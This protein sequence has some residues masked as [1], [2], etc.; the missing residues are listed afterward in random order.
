MLR[1]SRGFLVDLL[2]LG[3]FL[4]LVVCYVYNY[5]NY[6]NTIR[7]GDRDGIPD[8]DEMSKYLTDPNSKDTDND[9]LADYQEFSITT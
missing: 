4:T 3:V 8:V 6:L 1:L 9:G 7:D 2:V 5:Y